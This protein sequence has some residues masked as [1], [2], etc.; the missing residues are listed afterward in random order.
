MGLDPAG[1]VGTQRSSS[2]MGVRTVH[3]AR[4]SAGCSQTRSFDD[5]VKAREW[6]DSHVATHQDEKVYVG[7]HDPRTRATF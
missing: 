5:P 1:A 6:L 4:C 3:I 7:K 2:L